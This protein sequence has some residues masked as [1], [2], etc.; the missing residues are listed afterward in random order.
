M[1]MDVCKKARRERPDGVNEEECMVVTGY[2]GKD[3]SIAI[4]LLMLLSMVV[5]FEV[6]Q[7]SIPS[8]AALCTA[9]GIP[10]ESPAVPGVMA[11]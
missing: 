4:R 7:L 5:G 3:R 8:S 10:R 2:V 11:T 9:T 6:L 1:A